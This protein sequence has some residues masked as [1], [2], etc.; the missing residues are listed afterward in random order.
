MNIK[1]QIAP[2]I[3]ETV[4]RLQ[5]AGYETYIVGGAVRDSIL[6]R[7]PKD[8]DIS[9]S[10]TPNQI[11]KV[12]GHRDSMIVGKRFRLVHL[13]HGH[14]I[15]EISTFR[16]EPDTKGLPSGH[17][18]G[19]PPENMIFRDNVF[20]TAEEDAWRRDFTVNA[21]FYDPVADK[22]LDY[23][24]LGLDDIKNSIVRAI[25]DP[26][27]RFEEDP[28][29]ILRALKLV[30]QYGF[31]P[32]EM[33]SDA[34]RM[35]LTLITHAS[36]SRLSLELEKILKNPYSDRI[37]K[38][39]RDYGFLRHFLPFIDANWETEACRYAMALLT[40]KNRRL[41]EG[42][43][44]DSISLAVAALTIPFVE[45]EL[46]ENAPGGLWENFRGIGWE[47]KDIIVKVLSPRLIIKRVSASALKMLLMQPAFKEG[48]KIG[49]L[50]SHQSYPHGRE[51]MIIQNE[52]NWQIP[53]IL[54]QWPEQNV[55]HERKKHG[56]DRK[57]H[58][59]RDRRRDRHRNDGPVHDFIDDL[60]EGM[61]L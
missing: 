20:G 34:I 57:K 2:H 41:I 13:R 27:L 59:R 15:I 58:G 24:G 28:V 16:K 1:K 55:R 21:L 9:T 8:Y 52:T 6:N 61:D 12:F 19:V 39:F 14:E 31:T 44:R 32:D 29:R 50:F 36:S 17:K 51:L 11:C 5:S 30:G 48:R 22:I 26:A 56:G 53:D 18:H 46:G 43:Y 25:G 33:T 54:Q 23:T 38:A 47:V 42:L 3:V 49:S 10:A 7:I 45:Y 37:I 4:D 40:E 60:T 35:N